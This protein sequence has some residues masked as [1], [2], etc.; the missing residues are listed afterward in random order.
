[1]LVISNS[2]ETNGNVRINESVRDGTTIQC[3]LRPVQPSL[4]RSLQFV[5]KHIRKRVMKAIF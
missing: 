1:M 2:H 3:A 5:E 4:L